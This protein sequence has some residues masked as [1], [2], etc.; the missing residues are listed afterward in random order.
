MKINVKIKNVL[1][2]TSNIK[3]YDVLISEKATIQDLIIE[4]GYGTADLSE[5]YHFS[6]EFSWNEAFLPYI[7]SNNIVYYDVPY[8]IAKVTDFLSTH[9]IKDNSIQI[10]VG[11]PQ[12]GGIG[13][14]ELAEIWAQVY[15]VLEQIAVILD[16]LVASID[17]IKWF[18]KLFSKRKRS[19]QSCFDIIY[20][21]KNW[22]HFELAALLNIPKDKAK[23][24]L[25]LLGYKY[26]P[27]LMQYVQDKDIENIKEELRKIKV[28]D[29]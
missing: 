18:I 20:S 13:C 3:E 24:L 10:I 21:R 16:I 9:N 15:P 26:N 29:R 28:I 4:T 6:G 17:T 22:N 11:Y 5:Y 19:P 1:F 7:I 27:K 23:E 2:D 25:K 8:T 14:M 12:A